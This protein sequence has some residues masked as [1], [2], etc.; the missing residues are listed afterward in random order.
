VAAELIAD[1][2]R[3]YQRSKQADKKLKGLAAPPAPP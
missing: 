3:I 1:L 2:K